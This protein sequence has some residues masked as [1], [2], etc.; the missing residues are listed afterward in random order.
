MI[1]AIIFDFDGTI[2]ESERPDYQAWHEIFQMH[3]TSLPLALW[4]QQ[5]GTVSHEFNPYQILEE[6]LGRTVDRQVLQQERRQR[7]LALMAQ[8]T[9][10]PG[11]IEVI[12]A[13]QQAGIQLGVASSGTRDWV[14]GNL[15]KFDLRRHF[16]VV[17]TA[18]DVQRVKPDP[19]LY[20]SALAALGVEPSHALAIEDSR[21]GMLAAKRAGMHCL[22]V[23]NEMTCTMNF[24]E[25]DWVLNSLYE[26][27]IQ[28]SF[29]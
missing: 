27:R 28:Q 22:V 23:P 29:S 19:E 26:F 18:A 4:Q 8:E 6:Q 14:E 3:N 10:K 2:L 15:I 13:A 11:V 7:F 24:A 5:I 25:A 1:E 12:E 20:L 21:N 16:Q 17:R 9:I